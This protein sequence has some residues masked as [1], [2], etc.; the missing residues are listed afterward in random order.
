MPADLRPIGLGQVNGRY[1][2][3]HTGV[4]FDAAVVAAGRATRLAQALARPPAV[5]LGG[6]VDVADRLRPPAPTLPACTATAGR[7]RRRLLHDRAQHESVHVPRQPA[8]RSLTGGHA[9]PGPGGD[10][11]HD[12]EGQRRS[13]RSLAGALRG[14]GVK[15]AAHLDIRTDVD[16]SGH[17][18]RDPVPVSGRRRCARRDESARVRPRPDAV[19]LVFPT[20][21]VGPRP[22]ASAERRR[23]Q[24]RA[25]RCTRRRRRAPPSSTSRSGSLHVHVLT[26]RPGP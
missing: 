22:D 10:H 21:P 12:D 2:C 26:A 16:G 14:G 9:R 13:S 17:R 19:K 25:R 3:F 15:P 23:A 24:R 7:R 6:A 5:H 11:V 8:A 20:A 1:F 18:A 4:G